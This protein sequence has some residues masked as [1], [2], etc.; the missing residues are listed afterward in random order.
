LYASPDEGQGLRKSAGG[1]NQ[2]WLRGFSDFCRPPTLDL[3]QEKHWL[4]AKRLMLEAN[5]G[6]IR[7]IPAQLQLVVLR[8]QCVFQ[9]PQSTRNS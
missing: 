6:A 1:R 4:A 3:H 9:R 8:Q 2:R 7:F 5:A